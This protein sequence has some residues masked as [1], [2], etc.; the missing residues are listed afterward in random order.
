MRLK[1][2]GREDD[3]D[4]RGGGATAPSTASLF[5]LVLVDAMMILGGLLDDVSRLLSLGS[6]HFDFMIMADLWR[7][8]FWF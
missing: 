8:P 6:S 1:M 5:L 7:K 3:D 4:D 2:R